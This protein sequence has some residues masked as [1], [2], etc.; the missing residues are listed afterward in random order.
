[1]DTAAYIRQNILAKK[2]QL[3]PKAAAVPKEKNNF[4]ASFLTICILLVSVATLATV[5]ILKM[6]P[7]Q[8]VNIVPAKPVQEVVRPTESKDDAK[9][10]IAASNEK[11]SALEKRMGVNEHRLWILTLAHNENAVLCDQ[12]DKKFHQTGDPGFISINADWKLNRTPKTM[13]LTEDQKRY[14]ESGQP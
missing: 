3:Q 11:I 9:R 12:M 4:I 14:L 8:R 10:L 5:I 2:Q 7:D 13:Q 1:M 6:D